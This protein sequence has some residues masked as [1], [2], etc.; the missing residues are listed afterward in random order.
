[1][2]DHKDPDQLDAN[3]P[4]IDSAAARDGS[5]AAQD[6]SA[7]ASTPVEPIAVPTIDIEREEEDETW[8]NQPASSGGT[9]SQD[10]AGDDELDEADE[11]EE[12]EQAPLVRKPIQNGRDVV[13]EELPVRA[14][15][16]KARLRP[17]LMGTLVIELTNIGEKFLFDWRGEE[18]KVSLVEG[19][20][21]LAQGDPADASKVDCI[22][23]LTE[24]NLMAVRSGDLNPQ[25]AMLADKI[26]VKGKAGP[27]VYLFNL[28][29]PRERQ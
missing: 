23:S 19:P 17:Y 8:T 15:R 28:V 26:K 16:A 1:M 21:Q 11:D 13:C 25:L 9:E 22:V 7:V 12:V 18:P 10:R 24:Q 27:A 3:T 6:D 5:G 14:S 20:I 29:A 2:S 4:Q